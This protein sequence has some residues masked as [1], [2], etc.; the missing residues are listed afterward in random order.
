MEMKSLANVN[1]DVGNNGPKSFNRRSSSVCGFLWKIVQFMHCCSL[2]LDWS[3]C[4][5]DRNS[6]CVIRTFRRIFHHPLCFWD[7]GKVPCDFH[8]WQK[9]YYIILTKLH[10]IKASITKT[11]SPSFLPYHCGM[12]VGVWL[13]TLSSPNDHHFGKTCTYVPYSP[14]PSGTRDVWMQ[15]NRSL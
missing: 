7:L 14:A 5:G 8:S 2:M 13:R 12:C 3:M 6:K 9:V 1:Y 4:D 11:F 10:K 15:I